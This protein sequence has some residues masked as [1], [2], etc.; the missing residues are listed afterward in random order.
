[1]SRRMMRE[2]SVRVLSSTFFLK[3]NHACESEAQSQ[4]L[5]VGAQ[6]LLGGT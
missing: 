5:A 3:V 2:Q 4:L 6:G 1:M